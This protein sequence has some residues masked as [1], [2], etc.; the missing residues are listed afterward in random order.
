MQNKQAIPET[1]APDT[2]LEPSSGRAARLVDRVVAMIKGYPWTALVAVTYVLTMTLPSMGRYFTWDE[3]VFFSQSGG[4]SGAQASPLPLVASRE[5]GSSALL[6]VLRTF[7]DSYVEVR[8]IW[9]TLAFALLVLGARR[10]IPHIGNLAAGVFMLT[11]GT[12]WLVWAYTPA[13]YANVL[14]AAFALLAATFYLDL[15]SE[16]ENLRPLRAGFFLG[17]SAAGAIA[18]RPVEAAL[19]MVGLGLHLIIFN[20]RRIRRILGPLGV[21]FVTLLV[22]IGVPWIADSISRFGSV[23]E[24]ILSGLSQGGQ[25]ASGPR[26]N[27]DEYLGV[28]VGDMANPT[29]GAM[30]SWPR[31]VIYAAMAATFVLVL[32][33]LARRM[34]AWRG[35]AGAFIMAGAAQASFFLFW[36]AAIED[37]YHFGSMIFGAA[38][39]AWAVPVVMP[40]R[41]RTLKWALATVVGVAW[42]VAQISLI[43]AYDANRSLAGAT[44]MRV[45]ET[46]RTLANDG[47]CVGLSRY[48][49][50]Q[51]QIASGCEVTSYST[52]EDAM[53]HVADMSASQ[54]SFVYGP[55]TDGHFV[56]MP[57]GW[58]VLPVS[59][60]GGA[61]EFRLGYWLPAD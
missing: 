53:E 54:P 56:D 3:A 10:L 21:A 7:A 19:F 47:D 27:L 55:A 61:R 43:T 39:F 49:A 44:S 58:Q 29:Y 59:V 22:T 4:L 46:M 38:L 57:D 51:I 6:G 16:S 2:R 45:A 15:T 41:W 1:A 35:P 20:P 52:W 42:M 25:V 17:L 60:G 24:R 9:A 32:A 40:N 33:A 11:Y 8:I 26:F 28:W 48:G 5:L 23:T 13:F 18:M 31:W 12:F 36:R 37:R 14:M 50:P 34:G 30:P